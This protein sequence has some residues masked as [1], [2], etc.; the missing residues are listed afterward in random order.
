MKAKTQS[1]IFLLMMFFAGPAFAHGGGLDKCGGHKDRKQGGYHV[2]DQAR[3]C[4]CNPQSEN[5]SAKGERERNPEQ[6]NKPVEP[7]R[8]VVR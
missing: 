3:F 4:F 1:W 6:G 7:G 8:S 5:C 2:H